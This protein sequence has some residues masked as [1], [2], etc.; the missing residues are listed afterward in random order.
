MKKRTIVSLIIVCLFIITGVS[1]SSDGFRLDL[2]S[3]FDGNSKVDSMQESFNSTFAIEVDR[4]LVSDEELIRQLTTEATYFL[5]GPP[6]NTNETAENYVRR[7]ES[8]LDLRDQ[9]EL[10]RDEKGEIILST[11][12]AARDMASGMLFGSMFRMFNDLDLVYTSFGPIQVFEQGEDRW[13]VITL[14]NVTI[15]VAN[16]YSPMEFDE[17]IVDM[18]ITYLF[19][20]I[21]GEY[22][23]VWMRGDTETVEFDEYIDMQ[24]RREVRGIRAAARPIPSGFE[25]RYDFSK[26][27]NL[28]NATIETIF[29]NNLENVLIFFGPTR[30]GLLSGTGFF[31]N[32][33]VAVTSWTFMESALREY[34][35]LS[36]MNGNGTPLKLD[37]IISVDAANDIAL[38]RISGSN[39]KGVTLAKTSE[40]TIE[41]PVIV[42]S[43]KSGINLSAQAGIV[44]SNR[45]YLMS[46][47]PITVSETGS[48]VFNV[49]GRVVGMNSVTT[50]SASFSR[51]RNTEAL[52]RLQNIFNDTAVSDI[53]YVPFED[54]K[55]NFF[56]NTSA[57]NVI[58]NVSNR[59]WN[60]FKSVG[61]I[62]EAISLNL[63]R[64]N[65]RDGIVSLRYQN[66]FASVMPNMMFASEFIS[67]LTKSG[68]EEVSSSEFKAVYRNSRYRVTIMSEF[69]FL[70]VV[71]A[72]M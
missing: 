23:I 8:W 32:E 35:E 49:N 71:I 38:V 1:A 25:N 31:I 3:V 44:I 14:P 69:N 26:L 46:L 11:P 33:G 52:V 66:E 42:I 41:E 55:T 7:Q 30:E 16:K 2:S 47:L 59:R 12:E 6:N 13:S 5:L 21:D 34:N 9:P 61:D 67:N 72:R 57:A 18:K 54:L 40:L 20:K 17:R 70:V 37:G 48:P 60:R 50:N 68:F 36:V 27:N 62:E 19:R 43:T 65:Y 58:H 56:H 28:S 39:A 4:E 29:E 51:A 53:T 22:T 15:R 64:A 10:P 24:T 63:V 45:P